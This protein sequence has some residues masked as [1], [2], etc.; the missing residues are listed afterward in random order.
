MVK[1][2]PKQVEYVDEL[3]TV[4]SSEILDVG[5]VFEATGKF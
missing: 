5:L 3:S 4:G 1:T 2:A